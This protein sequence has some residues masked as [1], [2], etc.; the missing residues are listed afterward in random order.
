MTLRIKVCGMRDANNIRKVA[1]LGIYFMGFIFYP[2][3]P[4]YAGDILEPSVVQSLPSSIRR[5]GVFVNAKQEDII[6]TADSYHL[7]AVQ[8]HGT[9]SPEFCRAM[10][11][12]G[13]LVLKAFGIAEVFD[14]E[15]LADYITHVDY[16]LFDTASVSH[17]GS[18]KKFTWD[19]LKD[20]HLRVPFLLSG[21][22]GPE[23]TEAIRS[24]SHHALMGV[25]LNSKFETE[26]GMKDEQRLE[27]F[28]QQLKSTS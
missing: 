26:P 22:I 24:V 20:Y 2:K 1:E 15:E 16:F 27:S 14:F 23:D 5:V 8:L 3:S 17:G 12:Q 4:R 6:R 10:K 13:L 21:G 7:D 9:E 18:G 11:L 19:L 25:D 28:L